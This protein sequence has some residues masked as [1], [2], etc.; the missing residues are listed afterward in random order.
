MVLCR[1]MNVLSKFPLLFALVFI[2]NLT[3]AANA[4]VTAKDLSNTYES[5]RNAMVRKDARSWQSLTSQRRQVE[6]KNRIL[7]AKAPFPRA[8]FDT[9]TA[10]PS[11]RGL[12]MVGALEKHGIAKVT[13]FGKVNFGIGGDPTNNLYVVSFLNEGGRW[14]YDG[15][16]FV[17]LMALPDVRKQL[18]SGDTSFIKGADFQPVSKRPPVPKSVDR[19][20][21][22]AKVYAF[23]PGRAVDVSINGIS[24]HRFQNDQQAQ[25]VIGGAKDGKNSISCKIRTLEGGLGNEAFTVRVYLVNENDLKTPVKIYEYLV[26]EGGK[27]KPSLNGSFAITPDLGRRLLRR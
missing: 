1:Q 5:W 15:A 12:K 10:P 19:V 3:S 13:W 2:V 7:S 20:K 25:V 11:I 22:I 23:C 6:V 8:L 18:E 14:K 17:N 21:Y 27:V 24:Q 26:N 4:Q 9:P 16:E